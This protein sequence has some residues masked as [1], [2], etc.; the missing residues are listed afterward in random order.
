MLKVFSHL[1]AYHAC[2]V[3]LCCA[4]TV[5]VSDVAAVVVI[6]AVAAA[7]A[8]SLCVG[9]PVLRTPACCSGHKNPWR[10]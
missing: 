10:F 6:L 3:P 8:F 1:S 5:A 9:L 4:A 7:P 2:C